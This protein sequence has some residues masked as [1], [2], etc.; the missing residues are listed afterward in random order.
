MKTK[1]FSTLLLSAALAASLALSVGCS[2]E[3]SHSES[4]HPGWFGGQTTKETTVY[5]NTDGTVSTEHVEETTK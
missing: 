4:D 2:H 1:L 5:Q 3:V